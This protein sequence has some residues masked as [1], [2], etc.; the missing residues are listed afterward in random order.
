MIATT[1]N[2]HCFIGKAIELGPVPDLQRAEQL[3]TTQGVFYPKGGFGTV[4][5]ALLEAAETNGGS[6]A[7]RHFHGYCC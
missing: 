4:S 6:A 3:P 1:T 7:L 2:H 5:R